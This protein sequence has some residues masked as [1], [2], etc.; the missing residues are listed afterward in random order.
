[1]KLNVRMKATKL[2]SEATYHSGVL[3]RSSVVSY[4]SQSVQISLF[5]VQQ[6][7]YRDAALERHKQKVKS[8]KTQKN[9]ELS[10]KF[11]D[12][13]NGRTSKHWALLSDFIHPETRRQKMMMRHCRGSLFTLLTVLQV[14][15]FRNHRWCISLEFV[16][17]KHRV[18]HN[19]EVE[20]NLKLVD[21]YK[22]GILHYSSNRDW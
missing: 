18:K 1:M 4:H 8:H 19:C 5:S 2:Q 22:C 21:F 9:E 10:G 6:A 20:E 7:C 17:E 14:L 11:T 13:R 3:L 16:Q 12:K 15:L